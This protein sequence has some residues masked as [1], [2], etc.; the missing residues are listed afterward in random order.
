MYNTNLGHFTRANYNFM[1]NYSQYILNDIQCSTT[2]TAVF[3]YS[4]TPSC[5]CRL[6]VD[7]VNINRLLCHSHKYIILCILTHVHKGIKY[8][9]IYKYKFQTSDSEEMHTVHTTVIGETL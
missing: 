5:E 3:L 2:R 7:D 4:W 6:S 9:D 1:Y 8:K